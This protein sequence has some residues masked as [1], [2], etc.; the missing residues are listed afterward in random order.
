M[1]RGQDFPRFWPMIRQRPQ[2][3]AELKGN[4]FY[5]TIRGNVR[6]Y[7][8]RYGAIVVSEFSGLPQVTESCRSPIFEFH[9]HEGNDCGGTPER[10]FANARTH[11]NPSGCR[12]PYHA[13]DMPPIFGANGIAFSAFLTDRFRVDE[14]VGRTVILH[15]APDDFTTQPSGNAGAMIACGVVRR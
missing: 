6:F 5:P 7:Q 13:G 1:Y 12:H 15:D 11:Y 8:T 4:E 14:I 2:A 9:I 3:W 10:P